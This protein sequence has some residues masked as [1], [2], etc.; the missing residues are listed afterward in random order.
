MG[1][2]YRVLLAEQERLEQIYQKVAERLVERRLRQVKMIMKDYT[3]DEIEKIF[4]KTHKEKKKWIRPVEKD[5]EQQLDEWIA[6]E[7]QGKAFSEETAMILTEKGER[8]RS[9]SEKFWRIIFTE[10]GFHIN[11]RSRCI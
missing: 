7:Y 4:L 8:V 2:F 5:W 9:K 10:A 6:E 11:M 1:D 3:E